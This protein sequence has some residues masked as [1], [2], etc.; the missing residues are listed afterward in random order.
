[1][2]IDNV[3]KETLENAAKKK[4]KFSLKRAIATGL[5]IVSLVPGLTGC[6]GKATT[7]TVDTT[8]QTETT[9]FDDEERSKQTIYFGSD[10][11]NTAVEELEEFGANVTKIYLYQAFSTDDLSDIAEYCPNL[12]EIYIDY[13]PSITDLTFI[14]SLPNLKKV[15][16]EEN[17]FVTPELV[18]YLDRNEIEHNIVQQDL[19]NAAEIQSILDEIITEDM[20]DEEKIQAVTYYVID[21]YKYKITK[22]FESNAD[23][24]TST[25]KNG[26][27]VCASYAYLTNILL[28]GAG[29][30]SYEVT[31]SEEVLMGHA[32][33]VIE[34]DG[35]YYYLDA[36][37][38]KQIPII[39]KLVLKYF[40][41][42]FFY[43]TDPRA[44]GLSPMKDFDKAEKIT[45]PE[46]M[47]ADIERGENEKTIFEKY[48]NSVP[49]RIIEI[50][51]AI[52]A[53]TAGVT[54]TTKGIGAVND[55]I[56]EKKR[57]K[58]ER[59]RRQREEQ[60]RRDAACKRGRRYY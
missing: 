46:E 38:I 22:V 20:T 60:A 11:T 40:N 19:D 35:K 13:C 17:G 4:R 2:H 27:G 55:T 28:R 49:A 14:Y 31:T 12:E 59:E 6:G 21:N 44:T 57:R 48:G 45:I 1:M 7:E 54:L 42:G 43:M 32:W 33:N 16:I 39:S 10:M 26:G 24:L 41:V 23:P 5:V 9:Y 58:R 50:V 53:I 18:E 15:S 30:K 37:N 25:L 47:I 56:S 36:T 29:I 52:T 8:T 3:N 34:I 51:L